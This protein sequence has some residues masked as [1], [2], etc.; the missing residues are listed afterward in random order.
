MHPLTDKTPVMGRSAQD[1]VDTRRRHLE[2]VSHRNRVFHIQQGRQLMADP[3]TIF[4]TNPLEGA[5]F[6][7][8]VAYA[9]RRYAGWPVDINA[10]HGL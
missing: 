4:D 9:G 6:V 5:V 10:Q 8:L 3:F 1:A 2:G 7:R